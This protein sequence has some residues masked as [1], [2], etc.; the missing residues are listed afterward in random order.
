MVLAGCEAGD[1]QRR[2]TRIPGREHDRCSGGDAQQGAGGF[3]GA[4]R[5]LASVA[6]QVR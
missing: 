5:N 1:S 6:G 2:G 4:A 3:V